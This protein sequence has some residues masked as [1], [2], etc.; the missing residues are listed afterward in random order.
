MS[1]KDITYLEL[2]Q[3]FVQRSRTVCA[4]LVEGIK[5]N[6]SVKVF[7]EFGPVVQEEMLFKRFL[8]WSYGVPHVRQS[9]IICADLVE[10]I[11]WSIHVK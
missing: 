1:F 3:P 5:R 4:I 10:G 8:I 7:F 11:I 2:W 9:G 6:N